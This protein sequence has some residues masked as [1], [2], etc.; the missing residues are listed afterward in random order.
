MISFSIVGFSFPV[1]GNG[2]YVA[3]VGTFVSSAALFLDL[4]RSSLERAGAI[5]YVGRVRLVVGISDLA[6]PYRAELEEGVV[7]FQISTVKTV[8]DEKR[9]IVYDIS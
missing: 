2:P 8:C 7:G 5:L 4:C 6:V 3:S 1:Q 9:N